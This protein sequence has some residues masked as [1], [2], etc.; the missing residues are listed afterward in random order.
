MKLFKTYIIVVL[1]LTSSTALTFNS[2]LDELSCISAQPVKNTPLI[3][4]ADSLPHFSVLGEFKV[5]VIM[6]RFASQASDEQV[7]YIVHG[8]SQFKHP[9]DVTIEM[10]D[11]IIFDNRYP[12]PWKAPDFQFDPVW[13][14]EIMTEFQLMIISELFPTTV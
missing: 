14:W 6:V 7:E 10:A 8:S 11:T 1:L 4:L 9:D 5:L 13:K 2:E 3:S 12:G